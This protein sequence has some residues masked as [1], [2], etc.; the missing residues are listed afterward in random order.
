MQVEEQ[1][2]VDRPLVVRETKTET[3]PRRGSRR[4][5]IIAVVAFLIVVAVVIAGIVPRVKA[6]ATLRAETNQLAV[7]A[8]LVVQPKHAAP[9]QEIV[10]PANVQ[11]FKDAPIYARTNGYLRH[12][13]ADIGTRVKAGQLLAEIDTPEVVQQLD[14]ARNDGTGLRFEHHL[15]AIL[16]KQA[17]LQGDRHGFADVTTGILHNH[18][19]IN[20]SDNPLIV[21][22]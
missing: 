20:G 12:W 19:N 6:R 10:L 17:G 2:N 7:P 16:I 22:F 9:G 3:P 4:S 13:T 21:T 8:V 18:G 15:V 14:Q 1:R 11:A 5:W